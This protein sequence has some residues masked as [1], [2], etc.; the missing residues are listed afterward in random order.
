MAVGLPAWHAVRADHKPRGAVD[1][2]RSWVSDEGG[3][4]LS[5]VLPIKQKSPPWRFLPVA[6]GFAVCVTL[7]ALGAKGFRLRWP[8]DVLVG[9]RKLAGLLL[10]QF[11]PDLVVA[12]IGVNVTNQR[13]PG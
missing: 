3:L 11:C 7:D 6:V 1:Y 4:W 5:A 8:N 13:D 9:R 12:G 10:D 2:E